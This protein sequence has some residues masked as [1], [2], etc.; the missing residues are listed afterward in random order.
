MTRKNG[1][2]L[3]L[4]IR[5]AFFKRCDLLITRAKAP[6]LNDE[7]SDGGEG[8]KRRGDEV[9]RG[10][11]AT[12]FVSIGITPS[13]ATLTCSSNPAAACSR[14]TFSALPVPMLA[15]QASCTEHP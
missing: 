9:R 10:H 4:Q 3:L 7:S 8:R 15:R 14:M 6:P 2:E 11:H 5:D 1:G 13:G 12:A